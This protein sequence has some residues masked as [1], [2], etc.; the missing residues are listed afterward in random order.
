MKHRLSIF[1]WLCIMCCGSILKG[2]QNNPFNTAPSA[3]QG[4]INKLKS[5]DPLPE[6][7]TC[8]TV[9]SEEKLREKFPNRYSTEMFEQRLASQIK[10]AKSQRTSATSEQVFKIPTIVHI[11]HG[12]E[13]VGSGSN[14]SQAQVISQF[15]ALNED[16]RR[17]GAGYNDHPDGADIN[18]EFVPV[19]TDPAGNVLQE[20]GIDRVFGYNAY[21]EYLPIE[22]E[23]KPNTIWNPEMYFNIWVVNFGGEMSGVLGYAQFPSMSGLDGLPEEDLWSETDGIV[24]GYRYF[25]RTE[26]VQAPFNLGRTT[27]HEVGHWL[28]LR[29]IWG[30]GDCGVDDFCADTPNANGPNQTCDFR[31]SCTDDAKPDMIENYMDY[32]DDPCMNIFTN[33]QRARMRTVLELSPRRRSLVECQKAPLASIGSNQADTQI[34]WYEYTAPVDE[35]IT[36]SSIGTTTVDTKLSLFRDCNVL[37]MNVSNDASGTQ[38]SQLSLFLHVGETI[39]ILWENSTF[40][41][42]NWDLTSSA[43]QV[44]ATCELA[45]TALEGSNNLPVTS[46]GTYWY[47]FSPALDQTKISISSGGK[48][49]SIYENNC[50]QLKLLKSGNAALTVYDISSSESIFISFEAMGGNFSWTLTSETI[51]IGEACSDAVVANEGKN[52]IPYNSP[53]EYWYSFTMPYDGDISIRTADFDQGQTKLTVL[54]DCDGTI[55]SSMSGTKFQVNGIALLTGE[56]VRILWDGQSSSASFEWYLQPLEYNNGEICTAAK[57]AQP[58]IN[59]TDAAPQWF[60]Y[61]TTKFTNL[62]ISSVGYTEVNTHL[63]VKRECDGPFTNAVDDSNVNDSYSEQS[64]LVL[65]GMNAGEQVYILWSEKWSYDGFDWVIEEIEPLAGDNCTTAKEAIIGINTV[66]FNEGHSH[67]AGL[68]WNKFIVPDDN[69]KVVVLSHKSIDMAIYTHNNCQ[70]YSWVDNG[71]GKAMAIGYPAGTELLIVWEGTGIFDDFTFE[72][73]VEDIVA[74]DLC[75]NPVRA[76][77]G[78][79][80]SQETPIWYDYVMAQSGRLKLSYQGPN[81]SVI[82]FVGV[83]KGCGFDQEILTLSAGYA[84]IS[85][86]NA[87]DHLSILWN[88]EHPFPGIQWTLEEFPNQKGDICSNPHEAILGI[89]HADYATQWYT[90]TAE[91]SG[92]FIIS[93]MPFTSSDT[94]LRVYD[95]CGGN[96]IA[97]SDNVFSLEDYFDYYQSEVFLENIQ[98]GQTIYI[99]WDGKYAF[100]AFDWELRTDAARPGDSCD[101]PLEAVEG[102]NKALRGAPVWFSYTMPRTTSLT[103]NSL[104]FT[105]VQVYDACNGNLLIEG[106]YTLDEQSFVHL[107]ELQEGQTVMIRWANF[108]NSAQYIHHWRLY[109]DAAEPGVN[110]EFAAEAQLG[111]NSAPAYYS[112]MYWYTYTMPVNNKKLVLTRLGYNYPYIRTVGVS[113]VCEAYGSYAISEDRVEVS[114]LTIG[115]HV[116]IFWGESSEDEKSAFDWKLELADIE[117]GFECE[118]PIEVIPGVHR[119]NGT[120]TWYQYTMPKQGNVRISSMGFNENSIANTYLEVFDGCNGNLI[121]YNDNP[122]D[123]SSQMSQVLLENVAAGQTLWIYWTLANSPF[124]FGFD[125]EL[126]VENVENAAPTLADITFQMFSNSPNGTSIGSLNGQDS[127]G[128]QLYYYIVEGNENEVFELNQNTGVLKI[129]NIDNL[130]MN[131]DLT[132]IDVMVTDK[133]EL[134]YAKITIELITAIDEGG[135]NS[136]RVFPN[137]AIDR[138]YLYGH[139]HFG[140]YENFI[141]DLSGSIVKTFAPNQQ[142]FAIQEL[143]QGVY[144]LNLVSSGKKY[145]IKIMVIK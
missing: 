100:E 109:L 80:T 106:G 111:L 28:G 89:N 135:F 131:N 42:F 34:S 64:E 53:F 74:G 58:G 48:Q 17:L 102:E 47:Q 120:A 29:H 65:F 124:Q 123:R 56:T 4:K 101:N 75:E 32:S 36:L 108:F 79:N 138:V 2:Q 14:I 24:I 54:N 12:G 98:A 44:G 99:K 121:A 66:D 70:T 71:Q 9:E 8:F 5:N 67:F 94:Y 40:D 73:S 141:V 27:T 105:N 76:V 145:V 41:S 55:L 137:P 63:M 19:L 129:I 77:Q 31:D 25:G 1:L 50:N 142:E 119:S 92:N 60:T 133:I 35:V 110:C 112:S 83:V 11:V 18:I 116:Y 68:F 140:F 144:F 115:D 43:Q 103:L 39:K 122:K 86:L 87:G 7:R 61:T 128:D 104:G 118:D 52:V 22:Y 82:P 114:G 117:T 143:K 125:W 85:E 20:P 38:Q 107:E 127:D 37:P 126:S 134:T 6:G 84:M 21:Y 59:H 130:V 57:Q 95:D 46:L 15:D 97:E 49:F 13:K 96:L 132:V 62:K 16:F 88:T 33:D 90:Y 51:R 45:E 81:Y 10:L 30:D 136:L 113:P 26:N 91:T 93:S 3:L 72:L 139:N 69:K 78:L 23:L